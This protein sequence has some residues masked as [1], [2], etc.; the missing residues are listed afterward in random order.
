MTDTGD[1]VGNVQRTSNN[2]IHVSRFLNQ[3]C[4]PDSYLESISLTRL[5]QNVY[6]HNRPKADIGCQWPV[7]L[8]RLAQQKSPSAGEPK[9]LDLGLR[10]N[11]DH[12]QFHQDHAHSTQTVDGLDHASDGRQRG[13]PALLPDDN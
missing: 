9:W 7:I 10:K 4:A 2:R 6:Q 1:K 5:L 13:D 11:E 12:D 3:S 8:R